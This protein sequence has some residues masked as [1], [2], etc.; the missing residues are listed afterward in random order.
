MDGI[1]RERISIVMVTQASSILA[2]GGALYVGKKEYFVKTEN[3][4]LK[5]I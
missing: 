3:V 2:F 1:R 5:E 4:I